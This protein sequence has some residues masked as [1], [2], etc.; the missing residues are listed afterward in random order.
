[1][2]L[3]LWPSRYAI[4]R[5]GPTDAIPAWAVGGA[6]VSITRTPD[7]TS[8]VCPEAEIPPS[9]QAE[10]GYRIFQVEGP[11]TFDLVG[12]LAE[13]SGALARAQITVFAISTYDTDYLLVR[14]ADLEKAV[15]ALQTVC[16]IQA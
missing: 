7:E 15:T 10:R 14:E 8:I 9:G 2:R 6:F 12:I 1:M 11:L 4:V 13:L 16:I 3:R 5:I